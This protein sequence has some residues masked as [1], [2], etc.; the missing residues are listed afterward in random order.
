MIGDDVDLIAE[1]VAEFSQKFSHVITSGGIGPTHDDLTFE[2]FFVVVM[3]II[4]F[5]S[6][7]VDIRI[8]FTH[9]KS[10][11]LHITCCPI[12]SMT[13]HLTFVFI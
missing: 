2:G 4:L 8:T 13:L 9:M 5:E 10:V 6:L 3:Y 7:P 12:E 11:A 1:E